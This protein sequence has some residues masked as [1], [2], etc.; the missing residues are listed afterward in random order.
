MA[1]W[2][3]HKVGLKLQ[4]HTLLAIAHFACVVHSCYA[5]QLEK[6]LL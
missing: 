1:C 6:L 2:S 4:R 5:W 3:S